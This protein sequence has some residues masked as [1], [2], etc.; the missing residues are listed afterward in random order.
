MSALA[1]PITDDNKPEVRRRLATHLRLAG[2]GGCLVAPPGRRVRVPLSTGGSRRVAAVRLAW[3]LVRGEVEAPL[4]LRPRCGTA[5]CVHPLH[6]DEG[7]SDKLTRSDVLTIRASYWF[8]GR[9]QRGLADAY[10]VTQVAIHYIVT[11]ATWSHVEPLVGETEAIEGRRAVVPEV[12]EYDG[13]LI[14]VGTGRIVGPDGAVYED[15][16][17]AER[18]SGVDRQVIASELNVAEGSWSYEAGEAGPVE[19]VAYGDGLDWGELRW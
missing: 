7:G 14:P 10:G 3:A 11:R 6:V 2:E 16:R 13:P 1:V 5:G 12:E 4:Q 18:A 15:I 17:A 19:F 9:T 8:H